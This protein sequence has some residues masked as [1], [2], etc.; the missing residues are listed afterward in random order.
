MYLSR[1]FAFQQKSG[2]DYSIRLLT[3]QR[4]NYKDNCRRRRQSLKKSYIPLFSLYFRCPGGSGV[5]D[6]FFLVFPILLNELLN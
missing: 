3:H 6:F 4:P 1:N 5:V 2:K